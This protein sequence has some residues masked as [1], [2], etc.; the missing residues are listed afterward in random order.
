MAP[1]MRKS[2]FV[3]TYKEFIIENEEI[4]SK[5]SSAWERKHPGM[6]AHVT[7]SNLGDIK[8]HSLEVP[9]E[10]RGKG[11]GG[12]FVSGLSKYADKNKKRITLSQQPEPRYKKKLDTFY[13]RKGFVPNK[14]RNKD[15]SVSDT[16]IR[17][18]KK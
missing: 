14:G 16:M 9:K 15:F 3:K 6:K 12:R 17:N 11:I 7:Q 13:K 10:K 1:V 5:I 18:P 4:L 2:R 8:L